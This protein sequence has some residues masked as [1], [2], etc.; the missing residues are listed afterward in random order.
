[1]A[2][3]QGD[4]VWIHSNGGFPALPSNECSVSHHWHGVDPYSSDTQRGKRDRGHIVVLSWM[5]FSL[6]RRAL[7]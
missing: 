3:Q 1:M 6:V 7:A 2:E 5:G 4:V